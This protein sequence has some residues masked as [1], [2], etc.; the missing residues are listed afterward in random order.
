MNQT[1]KFGCKNKN[2]LPLIK[3][4]RCLFCEQCFGS[5]LQLN[6]HYCEKHL[7]NISDFRGKTVVLH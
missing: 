2:E 4:Y 5:K 6:Q 3:L 1:L 7:G